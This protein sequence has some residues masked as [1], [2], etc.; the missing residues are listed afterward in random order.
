MVFGLWLT[1]THITVGLSGGRPC[2]MS[3]A[4]TDDVESQHH[5]FLVAALLVWLHRASASVVSQC[6]SVCACANA[7]VRMRGGVYSVVL[8]GGPAGREGDVRHREWRKGDDG[9]QRKGEA[10]AEY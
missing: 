4:V 2:L 6:V 8:R 3:S 10:G 7:C 9:T 1:M 5:V